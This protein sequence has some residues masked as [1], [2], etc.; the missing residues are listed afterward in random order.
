M[1]QK[2]GGL[3]ASETSLLVAI[4]AAVA[5]PA[6]LLSGWHSDRTGERR[7][8][9]ASPRLAAGLA[10]AAVA[11]P[12]VG[13]HGALALFAITLSGIVAAYP[14][15]WAIPTGFLGPAAAAASIGLISSLGNLGGFAGPYAIGWVSTR[16]GSYVGGLLAVAAALFFSGAAVALVRRAGA[17]AIHEVQRASLPGSPAAGPTAARRLSPPAVS[18]ELLE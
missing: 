4:P 6:M 9:T 16:T 1:L 5:L 10:L 8:H 3:S 11:L 12:V 14:P 15:L 17:A 2:L 13:L 18:S 7:W